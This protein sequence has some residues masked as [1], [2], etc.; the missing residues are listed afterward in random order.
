MRVRTVWWA[1]GGAAGVSVALI[2]GGL[3]LAFVDRH[4]VPARLVTW[5]YSDVFGQVVNLAVPVVGFVLASR[6]PGNRIGW[7]FLVAGLGLG[8]GAFSAQYGL[9]ALVAAP[10]S[11]PAGRVVAWLSNWIWVIPF[12]MLAFVFLLFPT[13]RLRSPRWRPAGWFAGGAFAV[14]TVGAVVSATHSGRTRLP[15]GRRTRLRWSRCFSW[16]WP[17]WWS[18]SWRWW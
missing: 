15:G 9:H 14:T 17:R 13:G 2:A 10:G 8:V 18:A 4:L 12:T 3:A 5:D 1:A 11:L 6:R 7:L 16:C